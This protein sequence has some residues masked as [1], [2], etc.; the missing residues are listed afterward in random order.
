[1]ALEAHPK[2]QTA[3]ASNEATGGFVLVGTIGQGDQYHAL[4]RFPQGSVG[5]LRTGDRLPGTSSVLVEVN[6]TAAHIESVEG[7][8]TLSLEMP[9]ELPE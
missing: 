2:P 8:F 1:M 4:I 7:L 5:R 3:D 9:R 6:S